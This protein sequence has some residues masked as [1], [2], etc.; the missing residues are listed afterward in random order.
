M[1]TEN[2][3]RWCDV[4]PFQ[5]G[6][7]RCWK[8]RRPLTAPFRHHSTP[9]NPEEA[10]DQ[11]GHLQKGRKS[12]PIVSSRRNLTIRSP[13]SQPCSPLLLLLLIII[14]IIIILIIIVA[15]I[16]LLI[17]ILIIILVIII[18]TTTTTTIITTRS[19]ISTVVITAT[20]I[21]TAAITTIVI[22]AAVIIAVPRQT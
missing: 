1:I 9:Q 4:S 12:E 17:T 19:S 22:L 11:G 13:H 3:R 14:I 5:R 16:L 21:T 7:V 20:A 6:S 2:I 15:V 10:R 18:I 8:S